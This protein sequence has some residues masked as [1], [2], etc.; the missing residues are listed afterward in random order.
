MLRTLLSKP[1]LIV[2]SLTGAL[3]LTFAAGA[4]AGF[5]LSPQ[6]AQHDDHDGHEDHDDHGHEDLVG[7]SWQAFRNLRLKMGSVA[8]GDYWDSVLVPARVVE[9]PGRSDLSISA[10]VA[11]V[12]ER[13]HVLPGETLD[14]GDGLFLLRITDEGLIGAQSN[15]RR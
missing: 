11:G 1:V 10:P 14:F 12:A 9:I 7:L 8:R 3:V 13:I 15:L 2:A 6:A 5:Y 4:G